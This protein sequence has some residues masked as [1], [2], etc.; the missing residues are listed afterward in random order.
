[1]HTLFTVVKVFLICMWMLYCMYFTCIVQENVVG[2]RN[3]IFSL[4]LERDDAGTVRLFLDN[5]FDVTTF[6][7]DC[8]PALF[9]EVRNSMAT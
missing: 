1:M 6:F 9:Q 8:L 3:K 2:Y 5:E 7:G 4:A